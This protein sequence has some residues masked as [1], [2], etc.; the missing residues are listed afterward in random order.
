MRFRPLLGKPCQF[1][2][3][4]ADVVHSSQEL[5]G[6][7]PGLLALLV[8]VFSRLDRLIWVMHGTVEDGDGFR[9]DVEERRQLLGDV[10]FRGGAVAAKEQAHC[11]LL[12]LSFFHHEYRHIYCDF[13]ISKLLWLQ[14]ALAILRPPLV[15]GRHPHGP[16]ISPSSKLLGAIK[17]R[18]VCQR[19]PW[20]CRQRLA[21][22]IPVAKVATWPR[23]PLRAAVEGRC[24]KK[25]PSLA[26]ER[27]AS[28]E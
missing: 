16:S 23:T 14:R 18:R 28:G 12:D 6:L 10:V 13:F 17:S 22:E 26:R 24:A 3:D 5:D 7:F 9:A 2:M 11:C 19:V 15:E 1:I 4:A 20:G 8:A 21:G 25:S 27:A